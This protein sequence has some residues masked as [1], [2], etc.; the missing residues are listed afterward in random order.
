[1]QGKRIA[2]IAGYESSELVGALRELTGSWHAALAL[3]GHRFPVGVD[4]SLACLIT[5]M[6]SVFFPSSSSLSSSSW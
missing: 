4:D 6:S 1:M 5:T 3:I 2:S